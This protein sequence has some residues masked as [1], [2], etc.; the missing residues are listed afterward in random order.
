VV[1]DFLD[2]K[3]I[4]LHFYVHP[5]LSLKEGCATCHYFLP[6]SSYKAFE[7]IHEASKLLLQLINSWIRH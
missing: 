7:H 5:T 4:G 1:L 3:G 2:A 6:S